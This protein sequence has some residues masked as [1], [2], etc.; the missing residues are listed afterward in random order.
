MAILERVMTCKKE[1]NGPSWVYQEEHCN[2]KRLLACQKEIT[3]RQKGIVK[4]DVANSKKNFLSTG[5]PSGR[6]S[7]REN[8]KPRNKGGGLKNREIQKV[9]RL[10]VQRGQTITGESLG[11]EGKRKEGNVPYSG[12]RRGRG[13]K[14]LNKTRVK[15]QKDPDAAQAKV[16]KEADTCQKSE[17]CS[18]TGQTAVGNAGIGKKRSE[19]T[20]V[21]EMGKS[22]AG[23]GEIKL[24]AKSQEMCA[25]W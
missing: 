12:L 9:I 14:I 17:K 18:G 1:K 15:K 21:A 22:L 8:G 24:T 19:V 16:K 4:G 11:D 23:G 3:R 2:F 13:G 10:R 6:K 5:E 20:P 7:K 25:R